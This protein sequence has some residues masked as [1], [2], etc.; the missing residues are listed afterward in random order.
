MSYIILILNMDKKDVNISLYLDF[1]RYVL[2]K[3]S[4]DCTRSINIVQNLWSGTKQNWQ[5][6]M[7]TLNIGS[8]L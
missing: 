4:K 5:I 8:F 2:K 6:I 3:D 1:Y 7:Q